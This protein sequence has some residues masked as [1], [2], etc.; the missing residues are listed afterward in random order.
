MYGKFREVTQNFLIF[1]RVEDRKAVYFGVECR[2]TV[3]GTEVTDPVPVLRSTF[4]GGGMAK[5]DFYHLDLEQLA[6]L[7]LWDRSDENRRKYQP[8]QPALLSAQLQRGLQA[9]IAAGCRFDR[10][11]AQDEKCT[12]PNP[13]GMK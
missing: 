6:G 4:P 13:D 1:D 2:T 10:E 11:N 3:N 5:V 8:H 9:L 12:A 7:D